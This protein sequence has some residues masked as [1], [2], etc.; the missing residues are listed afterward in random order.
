MTR[1]EPFPWGLD[2]P[3]G[4]C[5]I[6]PLDPAQNIDDQIDKAIWKFGD[7]ENG[8]VAIWLPDNLTGRML[9]KVAGIPVNYTKYIL[10]REIWIE[11][12]AI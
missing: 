12:E 5:K 4:P 9:N 3:A 7:N 2:R 11:Q 6:Y 10:G 8:I 1:K